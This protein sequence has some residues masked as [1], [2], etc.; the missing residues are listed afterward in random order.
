MK[1]QIDTNTKVISVLEKSNLGELYEKL[2]LLF[3]E[4]Q[5]KEYSI[6]QPIQYS[7]PANPIIIKEVPN[8]YPWLQQPITYQVPDYNYSTKYGV[9]PVREIPAWSTEKGFYSIQC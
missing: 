7:W 9:P 3:P 2:E 5:W 1:L 8:S 4:G 6:E